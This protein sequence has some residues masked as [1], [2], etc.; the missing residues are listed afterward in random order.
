MTRAR[1]SALRGIEFGVPDLDRSVA[2][3]CDLWGLAVARRESEVVWLRASGPEHHILTLRRKESPRFLRVNFAAPDRDAVDQ[4]Y[5]QVIESGAATLGRPAEMDE[6]GRGYGFAFLDLEGREFRV[7]SDV[8]RGKDG[9]VPADK[10]FKLAHVVLN[11]SMADDERVLFGGATGFRLSDQTAM[12]DF[13][14]CNND[15]HSIAFAR[16]GNAA[17]NHVAFE[18]PSWDGLMRGCGRMKQNGF[19]VEWGVGRHGP[20]DNVFAYFAEPDDFAIEYTAEVQ[21]IDEDTHVP[22]TAETWKRGK[23]LDAW[24][25]ADMPSDRIKSIMHGK[26]DHSAKV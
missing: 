12:M 4:L 18:M 24:G 3:Y 6:P 16:N 7:L 1:I 10:P 25:F 13:L 15:H 17:L 20:G 2:F 11:S 21:Q 9:D 19:N 26:T 23:N 22:G 5:A 8:E 14:R